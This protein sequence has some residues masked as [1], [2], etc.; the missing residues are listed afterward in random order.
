MSNIF[1]IKNQNNYFLNKKNEWVD[2]KLASELY[3]S[4][5]KDIALNTLIELSSK[6]SELRAELIPCQADD[7]GRP[8]L[9]ECNYSEVS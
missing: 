1:V 8:M 7:K 5:H 2:G 9:T 6:D 3:K 4:I